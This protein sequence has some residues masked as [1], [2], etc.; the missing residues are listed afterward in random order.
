MVDGLVKMEWIAYHNEWCREE[1][2][3]Q[4][5]KIKIFAGFCAESMVD[6]GPGQL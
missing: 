4:C 6:C 2:P 1:I 5:L 3:I